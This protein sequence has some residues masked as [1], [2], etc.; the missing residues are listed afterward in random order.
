M[1]GFYGSPARTLAILFVAIS[2]LA[3]R[4]GATGVPIGGFFPMVGIALTNEFDD[5]FNT[6]PVASSTVT[7][8]LLGAG[9]VGHYDVALLDTGAAV[10][11]LTSQAFNDFGLGSPSPGESDGYRGTETVGIGGATGTLTADIN[12]PLGLYVGGLQGRSGASPFAMNHAALRGQTNT[13]TITLPEESDLPN[14]VGLSYAESVRHVHSQR[15][16]ADLHA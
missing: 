8:T 16:A 1:S 7:G 13:S 6:Y 15:S 11:L 14:V 4:V 5:D 10:S 3:S 2:C 12:D 9:G